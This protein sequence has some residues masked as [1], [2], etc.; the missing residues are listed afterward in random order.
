ML[1]TSHAA[2]NNS[3][4]SHQIFVPALEAVTFLI[5]RSKNIPVNSHGWYLY[6]EC[7]SFLSPDYQKLNC[8]HDL[9]NW[10]QHQL[11]Q[12]QPVQ[13]VEPIGL[14]W[15]LDAYQLDSWNTRPLLQ[16]LK[17]KYHFEFGAVSWLLAYRRKK[18]KEKI[19]AFPLLN[20]PK[21]PLMC[22][23]L[24]LGIWSCSVVT[25][26]IAHWYFQEMLFH[27]CCQRLHQLS[28]S[29]FRWF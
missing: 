3:K 11:V 25:L 27:S 6:N 19:D 18:N 2:H 4:I 12:H 26:V 20:T 5:L 7:W 24:V 15:T 13:R 9:F 1:R 29:H 16:L 28:L 10:L 14:T 21:P 17:V 23:E 8:Q 22:N